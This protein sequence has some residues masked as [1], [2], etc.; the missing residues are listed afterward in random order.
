MTTTANTFPS[1]DDI[2]AMGKE[3]LRALC[4]Q[5]GISYGKLNNVGMREAIY[6]HPAA[7]EQ[8][9]VGQDTTSDEQQEPTSPWNF[10]SMFDQ[11]AA[12]AKVASQPSSGTVVVD[13]KRTKAQ[14]APAP[15]AAPRAPRTPAPVVP[16][17]ERK[18]Y[19]IQ[20]DREERNGVKRPSEGTVCGAVWSVFDA[21]PN[22][23]AA[24]LAQIA[25][26]NGW[27]RTNVACEFYAWRKFMGIR[28]RQSK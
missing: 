28:G 9:P 21:K 12:L 2:Q 16:R 24:D 26:E 25:D 27:N 7:H 13:G 14:A 15:K 11:S 19:H 17:V 23:V 20:K 22:T 6:N 10:G 18:G 5:L 3:P 8:Q 1:F 4:R